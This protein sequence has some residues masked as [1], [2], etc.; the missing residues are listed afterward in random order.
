MKKRSLRGICMIL[1]LVLMASLLPAATLATAPFD[2][3]PPAHIGLTVNADK[4]EASPGDTVNFTVGF[5]LLS[6]VLSGYATT[7]LAVVLPTGLTYASS[8]VYIGGAP[9]VMATVPISTPYGTTVTIAFDNYNVTPG[10]AQLVISANVSP[11]WGGN[12]LEVKAELYLQPTGADMPDYPA[13][14]ASFVLYYYAY[15]PPAIPEPPPIATPTPAPVTPQISTVTF[16][17]NGGRRIGGGAL[18]QGI[19]RGGAAIEPYVFRDGYI[20]LEWSEPFD[21]VTRD[22]TVRASWVHEA[23]TGPITIDPPAY[24]VIP[25]SFLGGRNTFTQFCH[26]ALIFYAERHV[27]HF[28]YVQV[29]GQT[30]TSGVQFIAT[31]GTA[32]DT[33]AIHLRASYLNTLAAGIHTLRVNFRDGAYA[34]AQFTIL[35]YTDVFYDVNVGDWFYKGVEAMNASGLMRGVTNTH[36]D[37]HSYLTRGMVVTL[38]YRF[39]GEPSIAGFTNNFPDVAPGQYYTNA[40]M[41]GAANGMVTGHPNGLFAPSDIMTREQFA[42]VLYRFQN[43]LG[44]ITDDI[45][46]D[47][48]YRDFNQINMYARSPVTKLTMQSVFRDWPNSPSRYFNPQA[49][50]TRAEVATVMRLWIESIGW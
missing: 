41:W 4:Y 40:V 26:I 10:A 15:V 22:I 3:E 42:A 23:D 30:L 17:L 33:T 27:A 29:D 39:A 45:L 47:H 9:A 28:S 25:G 46:M 20:F 14:T 38:L 18:V 13:K 1:V 12:P 32:P 24:A 36:F 43:T 11:T 50:V 19:P 44:S 7:Q 8:I 34:N 21:Y 5:D 49:S 2:V 35:A 6:G 16:D 31:S 37:P 48:E